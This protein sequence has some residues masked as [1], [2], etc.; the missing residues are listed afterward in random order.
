MKKIVTMRFAGIL[1]ITAVLTTGVIG[2]TFAKYVS[3]AQGTA[4]ATVANWTVEV[5]DTNI[6]DGS[7]FTVDFVENWASDKAGTVE[8]GM[9]AP[10][11][12]GHFTV[13]VENTSGVDIDYTTTAT[14]ENDGAGENKKI[15]M[16]LSVVKW[17]GASAPDAGTYTMSS[18]SSDDANEDEI[19]KI[20]G[21]NVESSTGVDKYE[22]YWKWKSDNDDNSVDTEIGTLETPATYTVNFA[23]TANQ[24]KQASET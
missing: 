9:L 14:I 1:L 21:K 7:E 24:A 23:I 15:P 20:A 2:G 13:A 3:K 22:V 18:Y 17:S 6:T 5:N 19:E 16:Q 11:T 12:S 10:G 8:E 4:T